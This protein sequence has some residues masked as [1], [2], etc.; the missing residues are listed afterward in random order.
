MIASNYSNSFANKK[1]QCPCCHK[2][3]MY[4]VKTYKIQHPIWCIHCSNFLACAK[5]DCNF[6]VVNIKRALSY[7][8]KYISSKKW[9]HS[10]SDTDIDPSLKDSSSNNH[11]LICPLCHFQFDH[12]TSLLQKK[13]IKMKC[14]N[15]NEMLLS[16]N[17]CAH[18]LTATS[19]GKK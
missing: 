6:C 16:C 17:Y 14:I 8:K 12:S 13:S 15:Y 5:S 4:W 19:H 11:T 1:I 7:I 18:I 9:K 10:K 3:S 2:E